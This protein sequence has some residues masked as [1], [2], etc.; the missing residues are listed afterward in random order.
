MFN[1]KNLRN[2]IGRYL[3]ALAGAL[4]GITLTRAEALGGCLNI[5]NLMVILL[6]VVIYAV[7]EIISD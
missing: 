1:H 4:V 5:D 2:R 7:S 6:A 3:M